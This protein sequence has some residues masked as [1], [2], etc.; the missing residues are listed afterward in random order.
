MK[1]KKGDVV[2]LCDDAHVRLG[3][4]INSKYLPRGNHVVQDVDANI[5]TVGGINWWHETYWELDTHL[6]WWRES[7]MSL[8]AD[9]SDVSNLYNEALGNLG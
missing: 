6:N 2:K 3:A 4:L 9:T 8:V 7:Y 1:F 5:I